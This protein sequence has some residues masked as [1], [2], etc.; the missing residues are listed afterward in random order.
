MA[1]DRITK[2]LTANAPG[3]TSDLGE[4]TTTLGS[5]L[6]GRKGFGEALNEIRAGYLAQRAAK[7]QMDLAP[8]KQALAEQKHVWDKLKFAAGQKDKYAKSMLDAIKV[9]VPNED[10]ARLV[11]ERMD[12][13]SD[14]ITTE[15]AINLATRAT[16]ELVAEG[17]IEGK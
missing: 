4:F 14:D 16:N 2:L 10:D 13:Y 9:V 5:A 11:S 7:Q 1:E 12:T 8:R 15:N 6:V 17:T 3:V